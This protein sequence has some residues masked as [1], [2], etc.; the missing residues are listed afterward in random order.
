MSPALHSTEVKDGCEELK[1]RLKFA[2]YTCM[3]GAQKVCATKPEGGLL[4]K[5]SNSNLFLLLPQFLRPINVQVQ[6][7]TSKAMCA[8]NQE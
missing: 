4:L 2:D 6:L 1:V 3:Q 7:L 8:L 5:I